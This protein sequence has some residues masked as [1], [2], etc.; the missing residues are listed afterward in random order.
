MPIEGERPF[1]QRD[2]H[3]QI[4]ALPQR[5]MHHNL[6]AL[7]RLHDVECF[8]HFAEWE[9]MGDDRIDPHQALLQQ[10]GSKFVMAWH[11]T[12]GTRDETLLVVDG[13]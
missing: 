4:K 9:V 12:V 11:T 13:V 7:P 2:I 6:H 8:L 1:G 3:L 5:R 10:S